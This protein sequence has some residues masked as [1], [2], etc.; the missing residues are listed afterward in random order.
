MKVAFET[1]SPAL[2]MGML[3][4]NTRNRRMRRS[5]VLQYAKD[6]QAGRWLQTHQGIAVN[7]D[8]T[9]LD[10]QHRLAAIVESGV[11]VTMLVARNVPAASQVAMD[12][13]ARRNCADALTLDRGVQISAAVVAIAKGACELSSGMATCLTRHE[14]AQ[15]IDDLKPAL[16]FIAEFLEPRQ[17]G[18]TSS[19]VWS[20]IAVAWFYVDDLDRLREFCMVLSGREMPASDSD[21]AAV[22]LR[23]WLLRIGAKGGGGWRMEAFKKTQR[24]VV[25]FCD[26]QDIG[27]LY[28]TAVH[29][30]WPLVDPARRF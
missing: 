25:A 3:K 15:V 29:Y 26:R 8:G 20:A 30:P 27:K 18:V 16:G 19:A 5:L 2:A 9:I 17:R 22:V 14:T 23:E 21:R 10:G 28:G 12:D 11:T 6:M 24:A 7:C 1:I 13:H 4:S